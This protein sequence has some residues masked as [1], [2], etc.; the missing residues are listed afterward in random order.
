MA[1]ERVKRPWPTSACASCAC[2]ALRAAASLPMIA[3]SKPATRSPSAGA[4][5]RARPTRLSPAPTAPLASTSSSRAPIVLL[6]LPDLRWAALDGWAEA[7]CVAAPK[8]LSGA[9]PTR[10]APSTSSRVQGSSRGHGSQGAHARH[11]GAS[12][13][14]HVRVGH[15]FGQPHAAYTMESTSA[16]H[17]QPIMD[18]RATITTTAA[19]GMSSA[20]WASQSSGANSWG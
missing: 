12:R 2:D 14:G 8:S 19:T 15:H 6:A 17:T 7:R 5:T 20:S 9:P 10:L 13:G 3:T 1:E 18:T 11:S 16:T 4:M